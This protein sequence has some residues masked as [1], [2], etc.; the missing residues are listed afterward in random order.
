MAATTPARK[1]HAAR[2]V[3]PRNW[4]STDA[5]A[6]A[7]DFFTK[8]RKTAVRELIRELC[9]DDPFDHRCAAELARLVSR[10]EP[11]ILAALGDV[12]AEVAAA[13]PMEEWQA[14]GYVLVAAAHNALTRPQRLRL[15]PL[16]RARLAENRIAVR[17]MALEAFAILAAGEPEL[18]DEAMQKLEDARHSSDFALRARAR[19][20]LPLLLQAEIRSRP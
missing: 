9:S 16:V 13:L 14:R 12:L 15:L 8:P 1:R 17:A 4:K 2:I 3:I 6:S 10:R 18:R 11:G 19:L 5:A 20:M 7:K